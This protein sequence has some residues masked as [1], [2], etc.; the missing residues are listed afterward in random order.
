ML[1]SIFLAYNDILI[2]VSDSWDFLETFTIIFPS[3]GLLTLISEYI[4]RERYVYR[5][6]D[7]P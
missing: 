7:S 1:V 3:D 6:A 5:H 2:L 4:F